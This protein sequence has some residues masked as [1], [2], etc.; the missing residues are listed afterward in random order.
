MRLGTRHVRAQRCDVKL[1]IRGRADVFQNLCEQAALVD[2]D[3][4][5]TRAEQQPLQPIV[6]MLSSP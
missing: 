1:D 5:W 6:L 2:A 4:Q 3:R